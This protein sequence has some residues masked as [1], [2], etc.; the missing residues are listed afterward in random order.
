[1]RDPALLQRLDQRFLVD[2][3]AAAGIDEDGGLLHLPEVLLAEHV[4]HLGPR[5]G[6]HRQ[7]IRLRQH[8]RQGRRDDAMIGNQRFLDEGIIGDHPQAERGGALGD[9]ARH[10]A[11]R[12]EAERLPHQPRDLQ[13]GRAALGPAAGADHLVLLDQPAKAGQQQHHGVVGDFL[14]EGV[15]D[16]GD[17][18]AARGSG[19]DV[20]AVDADAAERDD[21]AVF[22]RVDDR[23]GDRHALGI[24]GIGVAGGGDEFRLIGRRLDDLGAD[25]VERLFLIIIAAAGDRET[26]AFRR[27]H[28]EFRHFLLPDLT[29]RCWLWLRQRAAAPRISAS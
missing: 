21:L 16:V 5:R 8:F 26:R 10:P 13:Q 19:F 15:G 18:D 24:D 29:L 27:H 20:D 25:R 3:R 28:P 22:E 12:D 4:V 9:R 7:E 6:M 11:E 17:G 2:G 14:D 1:M 23:F